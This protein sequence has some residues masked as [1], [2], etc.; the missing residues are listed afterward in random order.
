MNKFKRFIGLALVVANMLGSYGVL[1][2]ED[3]SGDSAPE[4]NETTVSEPAETSVSATVPAAEE[5]EQ[6]DGTESEET[7]AP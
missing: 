4:T 1:L 5:P 7:T 2:A 3:F 6:T